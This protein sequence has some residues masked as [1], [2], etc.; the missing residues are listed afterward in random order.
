MVF[1]KYDVENEEM[2]RGE[3]GLC[4]RVPRGI[5]GLALSEI[6][7]Q[8]PFSGY[9]D[10]QQTNKKIIMVLPTRISLL[11]GHRHNVERGQ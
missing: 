8:A 5:P 11:S 4:V 9:T 7:V 1:I 10:E 2:C 6:S 3:D